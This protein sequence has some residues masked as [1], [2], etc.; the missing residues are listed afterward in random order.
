MTAVIAAQR[1]IMRRIGEHTR[2]IPNSVAQY[3]RFDVAGDQSIQPLHSLSSA[4]EDACKVKRRKTHVP[5]ASSATGIKDTG[6][7]AS[8]YQRS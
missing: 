3:C 7:I 8:H 6:L 2:I 5:G 1:N 4:S